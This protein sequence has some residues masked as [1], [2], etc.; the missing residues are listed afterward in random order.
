MLDKISVILPT[1]NEKDNILP[2]IMAVHKE[3]LSYEHEIIVVDDNS[4]DGTYQTV[5]NAKLPF[6][7]AI[8]REHDRS[9]AK[10]IRCGLGNASGNV[11]V[12]MDS[13]FNHQP[14]YLPFMV[15]STLYYDCVIASRFVYGGNMN[16]PVRYILSWFFNV[17]VRFT[18]GGKITDNLAGFFVIKRKTIEALNYNDIFYGYGDYY[19]RLLYYLQ[20]KNIDILQVPTV[21]GERMSGRG[22]SAFLKIFYQYSIATLKLSFR[23]R[24]N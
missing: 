6:V 3:L 22:N 5:S 17:F 21:Y 2:L 12:I 23:E 24:F 19:I 10:S 20:K 8:L 13:D 4:S 7:K 11:F 14:K 18:I 15:D 9:L 16:N 1:Y